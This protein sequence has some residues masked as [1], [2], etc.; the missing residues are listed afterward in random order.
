MLA[1]IPTG[2]M[3]LIIAILCLLVFLQAK[4]ELLKDNDEVPAR[5]KQFNYFIFFVFV[6]LI[7]LSKF[8]SMN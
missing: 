1:A 3:F 8:F 6:C 4:F 5:C 7:L 2:I